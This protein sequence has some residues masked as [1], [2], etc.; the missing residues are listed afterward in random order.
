[1]WPGSEPVLAGQSLNSLVY[2]LQKLLRGALGGAAPIVHEDS[3]YRLNS[4][5]GVST[6]VERFDA[7]ASAGECRGRADDAAGAAAA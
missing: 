2:S 6:D 4:E 5:A 1:M 3:W 7:L